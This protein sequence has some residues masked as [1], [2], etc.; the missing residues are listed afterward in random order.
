MPSTDNIEEQTGEL[1]LRL[2]KQKGGK[3]NGKEY[4]PV[5]CLQRALEISYRDRA[6]VWNLLGI[7][8]GGKVNNTAYTEV[9]CYKEALCVSAGKSS[10]AWRLLG[11]CVESVRMYDR[12]YTNTEC[13]LQA[14][15]QNK[16][17]YKS[18][19]LLGIDGK[20]VSVDNRL[21]TG[22]DCF[23]MA[24]TLN[25]FGMQSCECAA[26]CLLR[27]MQTNSAPDSIHKVKIAE[28]EMTL[29]ELLEEALGKNLSHPK[30]CSDRVLSD[31]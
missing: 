12:V 25:P 16:T 7:N 13:L 29:K 4:T 5:E 28:K 11:A 20:E 2:G 18:W 3:V 9:E 14:L 19:Y 6:H 26:Q 23:A 8:G 30:L 21:Y 22:I 10:S 15:K 1:F 17:C 27:N 24:A 31:H